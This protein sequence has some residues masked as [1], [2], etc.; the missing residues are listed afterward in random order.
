MAAVWLLLLV[1]FVALAVRAAT[2]GILQADVSIAA[3]VQ[4][5]PDLAFSFDNWLGGPLPLGLVALVLAMWLLARC[6]P[7]GAVLIA[8]TY[9]PRLANDF[10][11]D[12]V[13]EPRPDANLVYVGYPHDSLS[14]PSGHVV[15]IT[16]VFVLAFVFAPRMSGSALVV[17][18]IRIF[19]VVV[20]ATVGLARVWLG[21]HWP[22]DVLGGYIYAVL[23]LIP[24]LMW[25]HSRAVGA[26]HAELLRAAR[27]LS[28]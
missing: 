1:W 3:L 20:V 2:G 19:Y 26:Q 24:A 22:S 5:L 8:L 6:C 12:L 28:P 16:L 11:K 21:A 17:A 15:G 9:V 13:G 23:F 18:A 10:V 27:Y 25:V 14:F 7:E 4:D